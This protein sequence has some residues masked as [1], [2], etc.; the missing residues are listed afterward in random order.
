MT[1]DGG[2][3]TASLEATATA[4]SVVPLGDSPKGAILKGAAAAAMPQ[5]VERGEEDE[6]GSSSSEGDDFQKIHDQIVALNDVWPGK[7]SNREISSSDSSVL[8][9][10]IQ[11]RRQKSKKSKHATRNN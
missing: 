5:E 2:A 10:P 4:V 3:A 11:T 8:L 7:R 6:S 1:Q 9:S